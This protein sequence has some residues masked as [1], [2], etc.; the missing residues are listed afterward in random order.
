MRAGFRSRDAVRRCCRW[1]ALAG[2]AG[3]VR[4][5]V[6]GGVGDEDAFLRACAPGQVLGEDLL[7]PLGER[8]GGRGISAV[9]LTACTTLAAGRPGGRFSP[10]FVSARKMTCSGKA[11]PQISISAL[12]GTRSPNPR[13]KSR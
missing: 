8:P 2:C 10:A 13:I 4:P 9:A 11:Q 5:C 12:P 6:A 1:R 3:R 7:L